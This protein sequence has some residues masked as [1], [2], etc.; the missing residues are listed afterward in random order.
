MVLGLIF[1]HMYLCDRMLLVPRRQ[2]QVKLLL[3]VC[4]FCNVS[5]KN[6]KKLP[7][8][9]QKMVRKSMLKEAFCGL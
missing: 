1:I 4:P 5:L 2:D 3:L 6:E 8:P 7:S 9:L